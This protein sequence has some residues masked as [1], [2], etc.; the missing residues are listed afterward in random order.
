LRRG[1][2]DL[3]TIGFLLLGSRTADGVPLLP[4]ASVVDWEE[5][6]AALDECIGGAR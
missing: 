2:F 6:G 3:E 1:G 5:I 4:P